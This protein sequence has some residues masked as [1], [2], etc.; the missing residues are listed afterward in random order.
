MSAPLK[1]KLQSIKYDLFSHNKISALTKYSVA[2]IELN[3]SEV[4]LDLNQYLKSKLIQNF[5]N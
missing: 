2:C 4:A 1:I 5:V 3:V